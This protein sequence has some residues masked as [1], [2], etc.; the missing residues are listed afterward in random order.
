MNMRTVV[1][2]GSLLLG[3]VGLEAVV[4]QEVPVQEEYTTEIDFSQYK[5]L[6]ETKV[7]RLMTLQSADEILQPLYTAGI[8]R[9]VTLEEH[10]RKFREQVYQENIPRDERKPAVVLFYDG[11]DQQALVIKRTAILLAMTTVQYQQQGI[12]FFVVDVSTDSEYRENPDGT[13]FW[14]EQL[15]RE[16]IKSIPSTALYST[17][18]IARKESRENSVGRIKQIDILNGGPKRNEAIVSWAYGSQSLSDWIETNFL[19]QQQIP[20]RVIRLNNSAKP[21]EI[22][23]NE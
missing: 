18:D 5:N 23:L 2:A 7:E 20:Q 10:A 17:F 4:G 14:S 9:K 19:P 16:N 6:D 22:L 1:L 11:S 12:N 8:I 3:G 21:V 15:Q 13:V